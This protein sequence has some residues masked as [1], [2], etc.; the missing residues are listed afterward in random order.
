M[1]VP[2]CKKAALYHPSRAL[3]LSANKDTSSFGGFTDVRK[4][5][6][7][8]LSHEPD[9]HGEVRPGDMIYIPHRWLH[10]VLVEEDSVSVTW[11]FVHQSGA[12]EFKDYLK[13][14]PETDSEF[15][16]LKYL[17]S[18]AGMPEA[19]AQQILDIAN[20]EAIT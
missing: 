7:E 10:D 16:V 14:S 19:S 17:Y 13:N 18:L 6:F 3:E 5:D 9:F 2:R 12:K 20:K 11:N 15:E 1:P 4:N 8:A